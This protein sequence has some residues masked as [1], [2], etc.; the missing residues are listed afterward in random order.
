VK[1]NGYPIH[2]NLE[3]PGPTGGAR[4]K[5][6]AGPGPVFLQNHGNPVRYRNTGVSGLTCKIQNPA[7]LGNP[8]AAT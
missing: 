8:A 6:E 2:E 3:L 5:D 4:S 7:W 1:H